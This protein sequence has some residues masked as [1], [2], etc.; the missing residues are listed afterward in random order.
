MKIL[1]LCSDIHQ[2]GGIQQ[3]NRQLLKTLRDLGQD[4]LLIERKAGFF[5][6][7][8]FIFNFFL[9]IISFR[10]DIIFCGHINFSPL[11][12]LV[13]IF[14]NCQYL[15]IGHGVEV[16]DI[17]GALKLKA[18]EKARRIISVSRHTKQ[19]ISDR[20]PKIEKKIFILPNSVDGEKF[21]IKSKSASL[22]RK[23]NLRSGGKVIL[24]VAR[25]L[26]SEKY[27]GY[28]KVIEALPS[29]LREIPD[30][31]YILVGDGDD[32]DYAK[33]LVKNLRLEDHFIAAG[34]V[35]DFE[36]VDYYNLCDLFVMPSKIEGFG[37]VFLEALACGKPVIAGSKDGA[38][39]PLLDGKLGVLVDPDDAGEISRAII[40]MLKKEI[41]PDLLNS[42]F[43]RNQVL[44]AYGLDK[45]RAKTS[46]LINELVA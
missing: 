23:H 32:L 37:I 11:A 7:V 20:L 2:V 4:V 41:P 40:R 12:Y 30:L 35:A 14:S 3:Y 1:F 25:L 38:R 19:K 5:P 28:I 36:L 17:K 24:T 26:S 42:A 44:V 46:A 39:D 9:G 15:I 29:V 16:W 27:K 45:L 31:T 18:L 43:L 22:L 21:F 6:K 13:N 33:K 34:R 8:W 10:P